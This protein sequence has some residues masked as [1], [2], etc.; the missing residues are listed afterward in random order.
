[1]SEKLGIAVIGCGWVASQ[2]FKA[3]KANE[4]LETVA[5]VD[6]DEA[7]AKAASKESGARKYYTDWKDA[8]KDKD[9]AAIII[10][11]PH[12]LHA[13]VA[14]AAAENGLHVLVEKPM[15]ISLK[16][17]DRMIAAADKNGV[18]LMVGQVL[19]K[20]TVNE[21]VKQFIA[22]GRI[23]EP[24]RLI[25]RRLMLSNPDKYPDNLLWARDPAK[26]GGWLLYGY[27]AHEID[28]SLWYFNTHAVEVH[29]L[30]A[31]VNPIWNDF[32]ELTIDMRLANGVV[33]TEIFSM[34]TSIP[35]WDCFIIGTKGSMYITDTKIVFGPEE[36]IDVKGCAW[37]AATI[38]QTAEFVSSILD[39]REPDASGRN[40]RATMAALEA[41]KISLGNGSIINTSAI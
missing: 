22:E 25:R 9:A 20:W 21:R 41:A 1:M 30:G 33:C 16:E 10:C 40:V 34:N 7:R 36:Q 29:A 11:L 2:H 38:K 28:T 32:D 26:S 3:I 35:V 15:A 23:G 31:K 5:V 4:R 37:T 8:I 14:I 17:T 18:M 13:E 39:K 6:I 19:R 24:R 12:N 27:G